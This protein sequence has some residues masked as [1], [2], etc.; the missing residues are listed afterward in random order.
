MGVSRVA[1]YPNP[2]HTCS[3]APLLVVASRCKHRDRRAKSLL[4]PN[5][6]QLATPRVTAL[7]GESRRPV[8]TPLRV[9]KFVQHLLLRTNSCR[10]F[11]EVSYA[12]CCSVMQFATGV[13][14]KK[15]RDFNNLRRRN[16]ST[17]Q[18]VVG[19]NPAGRARI[20]KACRET[21]LFFL[22]TLRFRSS[23]PDVC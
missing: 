22:A 7:G 12:L 8:G 20:A 10:T 14:A 6:P 13:T 21:G 9:D 5:R 16:L 19:S 23:L 1:Q 2:C 18:G 11:A 4:D 15:Q 17:N 3:S